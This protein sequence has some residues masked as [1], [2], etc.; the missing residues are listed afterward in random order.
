MY[1]QKLN[2]PFIGPCPTE[3]KYLRVI[4]WQRRSNL[5]FLRFH[6]YPCLMQLRLGRIHSSICKFSV[7]MLVSNKTLLSLKSKC[8]PYDVARVPRARRFSAAFALYHIGSSVPAACH[9]R[10]LVMTGSSTLHFIKMSSHEKKNH[11]L[12]VQE[13]QRKYQ[14]HSRTNDPKTMSCIVLV[15]DDGPSSRMPLIRDLKSSFYP[16]VGFLIN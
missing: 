7:Y 9:T 11:S 13:V 10:V 3:K 5:R 1:L 14:V 2:L 15:C 16:I 4:F 6:H 8:V 12:P